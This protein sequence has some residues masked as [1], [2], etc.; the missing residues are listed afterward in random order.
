MGSSNL[1]C[2]TTTQNASGS[3]GTNMHER[4]STKMAP[5]VQRK[6]FDVRPVSVRTSSIANGCS[7]LGVEW[8]AS[9]KSQA[10]GVLMLSPWISVEQQRWQHKTWL[11]ETTCGCA[12]R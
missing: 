12:G 10:D 3:S 2:L 9:P 11:I 4:S 7:M 1:F 8:D 5:V 6:L